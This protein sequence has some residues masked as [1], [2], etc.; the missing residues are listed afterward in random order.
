MLSQIEFHI[1]VLSMSRKSFIRAL[2]ILLVLAGVIT[3]SL[4]FLVRHVPAAYRQAAIAPG[5][6]RSAE[7]KQFEMTFAEMAEAWY[8]GN[9]RPWQLR[10]TEMQ[11]NSYFAED[12]LKSN[13]DQP[14]ESHNIRE[15]RVILEEDKLRLAFRYGKGIWSTIIS[16]DFRVWLPRQGEPN[17]IA[18]ELQALKAGCLP[19]SAQSL[20]K[21]ITR[22]AQEND[23]KVSWYR[24]KGNPVALLRI[25]PG[26]PQPTMRL[27][28]LQIKKGELIVRGRPVGSGRTDNRRAQR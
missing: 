5:P 1:G 19:I 12:F 9:E 16:V 11:I 6:E 13:L 23:M 22:V 20:L 25:Q 17:S 21:E 14:L 10:L 24:Y 4:V 2:S 7:S 26:Q 27:E 28:H 8:P 3:G 18:L 15:P